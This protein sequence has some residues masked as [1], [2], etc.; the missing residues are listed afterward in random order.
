MCSNKNLN[1]IQ[2]DELPNLGKIFVLFWPR[3]FQKELEE[4]PP[5]GTTYVQKHNFKRYS[6]KTPRKEALESH[7]CS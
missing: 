7:P 3:S 6:I 5:V 1:E 2:T 4:Q